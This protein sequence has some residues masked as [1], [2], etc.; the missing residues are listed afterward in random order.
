M[1]FAPA[2]RNHRS[3]AASTSGESVRLRRA[4]GRNE[5]PG[6]QSA[7]APRVC[8]LPTMS[9]YSSA[10]KTVPS[11]SSVRSAGL[12]AVPKSVAGRSNSSIPLVVPGGAAAGSS[13][14]TLPVA[15]S[16]NQTSPRRSTATEWGFEVTIGVADS[17]GSSTTMPLGTL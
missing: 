6:P 4:A 8:T 17:S 13:T 12:A 5:R 11:R 16:V 7:R 9:P 10:Q 1:R 2:S 3:P 14:P 15:L